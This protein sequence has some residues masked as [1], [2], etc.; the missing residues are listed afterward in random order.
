MI[1]CVAALYFYCGATDKIPFGW[2]P[3]DG[4]AE[5][6]FERRYVLVHV[7]AVEIHCG[8]ESQRVTCAKTARCDTC[9][10]QL[11]P[12]PG[13]IRI[14][15]DNFP[16]VLARIA[17]PRNE[18]ITCVHPVERFHR[19]GLVAPLVTDDYGCQLPGFRSLHGNHGQFRAFVHID[20][21]FFRLLANPCK[22]FFTRGGIDDEAVTGRVEVINDQVV[23]HSAGSIQHARIQ[24]LARIA[25]FRNIIRQQAAQEI[26]RAITCE[27]D[28]CHV[29]HV[30]YTGFVAD[31]VMFLFLRAV[32]DRHVPATEVDDACAGLEVLFVQWCF[33]S[34]VHSEVRISGWQTT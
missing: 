4:P 8:L 24:G 3:G 30:E 26:L 14:R 28:N 22:I 31:C 17:G 1:A 5:P 25:Y 23:N 20:A 7:G 19:Q 32:V 6:G 10:D 18:Q 11:I 9:G 21:E 33:Q 13:S 12:D 16:T 34:H 2:I 29:R 15:H 27:V